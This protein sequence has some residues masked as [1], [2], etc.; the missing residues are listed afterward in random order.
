MSH[1]ILTKKEVRAWYKEIADK[2]NADLDA[3]TP[4]E[5]KEAIAELNAYAARIGGFPMEEE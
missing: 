4:E 2:M 1:K 5:R 3:M